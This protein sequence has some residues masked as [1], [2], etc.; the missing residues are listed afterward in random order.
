MICL[1]SLASLKNFTLHLVFGFFFKSC[2][3]LKLLNLR[4]GIFYQFWNFKKCS[5]IA[6]SSCWFLLELRWSCWVP[7]PWPACPWPLCC[8]SSLCFS[9][10][11]RGHSCWSVFCAQSCPAL[12]SP[13]DCGPPGS[14][15]PGDSPGKNTGVG[16]H[17]LLHGVFPTQGSNLGLQHCRRIL[18]HLSHKGSPRILE[19]IA[20]PFSRS[21][22]P[23]N[24]TGVFRIAGGFFTS[25]ATREA[26][27]WPI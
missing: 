22:W 10:L 2:S 8:V 6:S 16:C 12:C 14:S 3:S 20:Y 27:C 21:S 26:L 17:A 11:D 23:R 25:W 4:I 7:L 19:C 15:V 24:W 13:V 9:A 18:Y 1:F 5:D